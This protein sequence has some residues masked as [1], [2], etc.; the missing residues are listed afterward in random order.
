MRDFGLR[1]RS[2]AV[3]HFSAGANMLCW[4]IDHYSVFPGQQTSQ[5]GFFSHGTSPEAFE[6]LNHRSPKQSNNSNI[7][8]HFPCPSPTRSPTA[9]PSLCYF[10][11]SAT[12]MVVVDSKTRCPPTE[13]DSIQ[14]SAT[15]AFNI[16]DGLFGMANCLITE[17]PETELRAV[18]YV[19]DALVT[20]VDRLLDP[21]DYDL[22]LKFG[23]LSVDAGKFRRSRLVISTFIPLFQIPDAI[24]VAKTSARLRL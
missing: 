21:N 8:R 11:T 7:V 5:R 3:F 9:V 14:I 1:L 23:D 16:C 2:I 24:R 4:I 20:R 18:S 12:A 17:L 10:F 22:S 19:L 13:R 6:Y 15:S